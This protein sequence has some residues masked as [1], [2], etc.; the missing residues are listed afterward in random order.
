MS[1]LDLIVGPNGAGKS[2]FVR[3]YL[4]LS[5]PPGTLFVN[6]DEVA[7][8][9]WPG[10]ETEHS[11]Q[12][13]RIAADTRDRLLTLRQPF[14]AE[15]VLSH[16]RNLDLIDNAL[17]AGFT[18]GLHAIVVPLVI[19]QHRVRLRVA[20]GGHSVPP[21]KI[22][23][24]YMRLWPLV[25][26]ATGR[27]DTAGVWDNSGR[28]PVKVAESIGGLPVSPQRWSTWTPSPLAALT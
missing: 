14:I 4:L 26:D 27:A 15:T 3:E 16:P 6:A 8:A 2:T 7:K 20:H 25:V 10:A 19:S 24:Q 13:A 28:Q 12:A 22:A 11:Y 17:T 18:V 21:K 9:R 1:R 5:L 23:S